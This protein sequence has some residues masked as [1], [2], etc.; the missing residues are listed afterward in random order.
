MSKDCSN[1]AYETPREAPLL[2]TDANEQQSAG[3]KRTS[4]RSIDDGVS[5]KDHK[6]RPSKRKHKK[7]KKR[8]RDVSSSSSD[9][10]SS[11]TSDDD[12][13]R[14]HKKHRKNRKSKK[15]TRSKRKGR[16]RE[17]DSSSDDDEEGKSVL[18]S[19]ITGK[20]IK[21]SINKT[22]DDLAQE[23]ARQQLLEYMNSSYK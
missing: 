11:S 6:R 20:K 18:R 4:R 1:Y 22:D 23:A 14:R 8:K 19:V 12:N 3:T 21:M 7:H 17:E 10:S 16:V 13:S 15:H 2:P 9:D 5:D